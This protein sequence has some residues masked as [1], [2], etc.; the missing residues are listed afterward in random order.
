MQVL[1]G[2]IVP[3]GQTLLDTPSFRYITHTLLIN[4][5][6][7]RSIVSYGISCTKHR[8][9]QCLLTFTDMDMVQRKPTERDQCSS[10]QGKLILYETKNDW[11]Q[12]WLYVCLY[13]CI[14]IHAYAYNQRKNKAELVGHGLG[15]LLNQHE[16]CMAT[17]QSVG[18]FLDANGKMRVNLPVSGDSKSTSDSD[19]TS[20]QVMK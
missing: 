8:C 15:L 9:D 16:E 6:F 4:M 11:Y 18:M 14:R 17:L 10:C 5:I 20:S 7:S 2:N 12:V 19:E 3:N 1:C 13:T